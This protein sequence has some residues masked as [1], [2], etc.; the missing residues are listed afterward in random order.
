MNLYP[1]RSLTEMIE[2]QLSTILNSVTNYKSFRFGKISFEKKGDP[3]QWIIAEIHSRKNGKPICS[4]CGR[5]CPIY[6]TAKRARRFEFVSLWAIPVYFVYKMRRVSC[7][8]HGVI[9][10]GVP[11]GDGKCTQTMEQRQFLANWGRRL[12]WSEVA[13]CFNTS[14]GKVFRAVKWV[15]NWGLKHRSFEGVEAI[16]VDEIQVHKGQN[17]ATVVYQLDE[18]NK[19]L[20]GI[21]EGRSEDSLMKFFKKFDE[22]TEEGEKRSKKILFVCS[23]MWKVYLNVIGKVCTNALNILDRFQVKG[24]LTDAVNETRKADMKKLKEEGH[25]PVLTKS[26]FIFLKNPEN[27]TDDQT[28]KLSE[29]LGYNL[30]VIRAYLMKE[31]FERFWKYKSAYWAGRFL[32]DWCVRAMRSKIEPMKKF[33]KMIRKHRELPDELVQIEGHVKRHGRRFQQQGEIDHEKRLWFPNL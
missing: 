15:V 8:E 23:D 30:R 29:L 14:F 12:S 21:E 7:P 1:I 4:G 22:G 2:M 11:W 16:G 3:D 33:V 27:L 31:D 32:H 10:E 26:K 28:E 18:G 24:H 19:R 20:L 5:K 17:Y 6:D 13:E 25:E 9:V